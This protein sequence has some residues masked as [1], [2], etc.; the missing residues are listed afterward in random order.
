M[1]EALT[2]RTRLL[3]VWE[4]QKDESGA[5]IRFQ[6]GGHG[7]LGLREANYATH[8]RLARRSHERQHPVGVSFGEGD[9][10]TE[11]S[12]ADNDVPTELWEEDPGRVRVL[13]QGH[14]AVFGLKLDHP[15]S[16]RI[17]A[18]LDEGLRQKARVWFIAHK[19]GLTLL[20]VLPA[21]VPASDSGST[22]PAAEP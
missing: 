17:R 16:A 13:F 4:I 2:T 12:R 6:Q 11:L 3:V 9:V 21:C 5:T 15:E 22:T 1:A 7:H 20:D 18:L 19:P 8:L 10:I 14:D